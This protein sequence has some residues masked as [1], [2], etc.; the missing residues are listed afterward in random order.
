[1]AL[2]TAPETDF[3]DR[4]H[5]AYLAMEPAAHLLEHLLDIAVSH[6]RICQESAHKFRSLLGTSQL[7]PTT[8]VVLDRSA[9]IKVDDAFNAYTNEVV[10]LCAIVAEAAERRISGVHRVFVGELAGGF[11]LDRADRDELMRPI[12]RESG[13]EDRFE[14]RFGY[15]V[16]SR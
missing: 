7:S 12:F 11:D 4:H 8:G 15:E 2:A 3:D 14:P 16:Y 10:Q 1:M 5:D 6:D 13:I 9:Q